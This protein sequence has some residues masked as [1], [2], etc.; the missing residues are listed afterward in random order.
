L[1]GQRMQVWVHIGW[2]YCSFWS[3]WKSYCSPSLYN[4]YLFAAAKGGASE[5]LSLKLWCRNGTHLDFSFVF[6][7]LPLCQGWI[8]WVCWFRL[9]RQWMRVALVYKIYYFWNVSLHSFL[10]L[11]TLLQYFVE[12]R[13]NFICIRFRFVHFVLRNTCCGPQPF[14]KSFCQV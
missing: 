2:L 11:V 3:R 6:L 14:V 8:N 5:G 1:V 4:Y 10:F 7:F 13:L 9:G 12:H